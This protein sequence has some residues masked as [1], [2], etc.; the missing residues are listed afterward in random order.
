[1]P[2]DGLLRQFTR[3]C[4]DKHKH[5][6]LATLRAVVHMTMQRWSISYQVHISALAPVA[7]HVIAEFEQSMHA[8]PDYHFFSPT[9]TPQLTSSVLIFGRTLA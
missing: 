5:L 4:V 2:S 3:A 1:M 8:V 7:S 6:V 9:D